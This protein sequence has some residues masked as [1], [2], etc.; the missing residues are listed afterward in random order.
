M[1][2]YN[3]QVIAQQPRYMKVGSD[4]SIKQA[5]YVPHNVIEERLDKVQLNS[6]CC[7]YTSYPC[8]ELQ[9][10]AIITGSACK[11][12]CNNKL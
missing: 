4:K 1:S 3:I 7:Y 2:N 10:N 9:Y 6:V 12:V 5:D 8:T 11:G